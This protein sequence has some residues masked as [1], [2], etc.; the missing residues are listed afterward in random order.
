MEMSSSITGLISEHDCQSIKT[1]FLGEDLPPGNNQ[2]L[3]GYDTSLLSK[4]CD[5]AVS[6]G[7]VDIT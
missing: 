1:D 5:Y 4:E 6:G 7:E 3:Q 2:R